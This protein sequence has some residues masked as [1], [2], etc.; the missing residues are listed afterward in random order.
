VPK[1]ILI[2]DDDKDLT[3]LFQLVLSR[4]LK[5]VEIEIVSSGLQALQSIREHC[6]SLLLLDLM[7]PDIDGAEVCRRLRAEPDTR[8]L[9][10]IIISGKED[11][12]EVALAVGATDCLRK[13]FLPQVLV[14]LVRSVLH[15][16]DGADGGA[17]DGHAARLCPQKPDQAVQ[18]VFAFP[19]APVMGLSS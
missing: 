7:L 11:A 4:R 13:P 19:M 16:G 17:Q 3:R 12:P 2:V 5:D 10:V 18:D 9:P 1:R 15:D 6:P 8:N 14:Q